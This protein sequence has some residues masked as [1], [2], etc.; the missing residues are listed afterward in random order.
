LLSVN[1]SKP[2]PAIMLTLGNFKRLKAVGGRKY[3]HRSTNFRAN[4]SIR[5][6]A[7]LLSVQQVNPHHRIIAERNTK[8]SKCGQIM[9][10]SGEE[11]SLT[12]NTLHTP[13]CG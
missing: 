8:K 10:T 2:D 12:A 1:I 4:R 9:F 3:E 13:T 6:A 5:R 11:I 7:E